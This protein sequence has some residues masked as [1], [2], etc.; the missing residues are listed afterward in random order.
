MRLFS[1]R[2]CGIFRF[3]DFT[4]AVGRRKNT[5]N[6]IFFTWS[7]TQTPQQP[8]ARRPARAAWRQRRAL[9]RRS[10]S[11]AEGMFVREPPAAA[12]FFPK[13]E[14][15]TPS[16]PSLSTPPLPTHLPHNELDEYDTRTRTLVRVGKRVDS[17]CHAHFGPGQRTLLD[18]AF[19]V[20]AAHTQ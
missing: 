11:S 17:P 20:N 15:Q 12:Q 16:L 19:V 9:R 6:V 13:V 8:C 2:A 4:C 7:M 18:R 10:P 3:R 5:T 14:C 1:E